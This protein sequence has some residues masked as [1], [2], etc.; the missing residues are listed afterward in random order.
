MI[1]TILGGAAGIVAAP[2]VGG[3][4]WR[5]TR[6]RR[7]AKPESTEAHLWHDAF[8]LVRDPFSPLGR[9]TR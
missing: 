9:G 6:Q 2:A 4:A 1:G 3:L 8:T 7:V 5:T